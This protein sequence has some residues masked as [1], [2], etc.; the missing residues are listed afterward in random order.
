MIATEGGE[1]LVL[2]LTLTPIIVGFMIILL[3]AWPMSKRKGVSR[4]F[5]ILSL[6]PGVGILVL[7]WIASKTDKS[8]LDAIN[9]EH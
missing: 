6:V 2:F 9:R 3:F 7:I 8:V 5:A 4:W 1:A